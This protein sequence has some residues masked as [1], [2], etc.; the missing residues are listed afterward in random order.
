[1][2]LDSYACEPCLLQR[3]ETLRHLFLS[4]PF[5]KNC[6]AS[7]GV[8]IPSWL[9]ATRATTNMKRHI[10]LPFAMEIIIMMCWCICKE[11]NAC[12]FKDEDPNVQHCKAIF[13]SKFALLMHRATPLRA[14]HMS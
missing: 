13:K 3:D 12:I 7:I 8:L 11:R 2:I 14:Q 5:A 1:M 9:R 10:G 6:W 4:C